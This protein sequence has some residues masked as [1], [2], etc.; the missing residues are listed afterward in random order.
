MRVPD[1][2]LTA[3]AWAYLRWRNLAE[4]AGLVLLVIAAAL[5]SPVLGIAVAGVALLLLAT[6][7]GRSL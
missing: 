6:F 5:V 1:P 2:I 4:L 3:A 7:A